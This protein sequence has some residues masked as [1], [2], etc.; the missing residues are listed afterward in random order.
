MVIHSRIPW[1]HAIGPSDSLGRRPTGHARGLQ[2]GWENLTF[3]GLRHTCASVL[4]SLRIHCHCMPGFRDKAASEM[5]TA[6]AEADR[7]QRDKEEEDK[8]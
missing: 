8:K 1:R 3:H 4:L 7:K 6:F 2:S 5:Q